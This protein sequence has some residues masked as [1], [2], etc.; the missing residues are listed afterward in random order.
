MKS[1]STL[2]LEKVGEKILG[3]DPRLL[4]QQQN[5]LAKKVN[6]LKATVDRLTKEKNKFEN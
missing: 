5:V 2:E 3:P 6:E 1:V 4:L